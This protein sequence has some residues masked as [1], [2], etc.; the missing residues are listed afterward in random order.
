MKEQAVVKTSFRFAGEVVAVQGRFVVQLHHH[1]ALA[2]HDED[3]IAA[4]FGIHQFGILAFG[5][6][7]FG[8]QLAI[9]L[10]AAAGS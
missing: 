2:G 8:A 9:T 6:F 7:F 1:I 10:A 4:V 5:R 3:V